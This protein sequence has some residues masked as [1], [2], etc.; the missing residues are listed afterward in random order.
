MQRSERVG[1]VLSICEATSSSPSRAPCLSYPSSTVIDSLPTLSHTSF[2]A[3]TVHLKSHLLD[4]A[5]QMQ[6]PVSER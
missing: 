3:D 1:G 2:Y 6:H 4:F 5:R